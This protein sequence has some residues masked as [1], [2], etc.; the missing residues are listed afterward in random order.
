MVERQHEVALPLIDLEKRHVEKFIRNFLNTYLLERNVEKTAQF[1]SDN[2]YGIGLASN[3]V[4]VS[5]NN[6]SIMMQ[7]E[8]IHHPQT[9][10]YECFILGKHTARNGVAG[11]SPPRREFQ[12]C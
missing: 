1:I 12:K 2:F 3:E 4:V 7:D 11:I 8:K 5:R 10:P 9:I 6:F